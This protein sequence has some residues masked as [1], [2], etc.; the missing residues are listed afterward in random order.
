MH[1]SLDALRLN[2]RPT[3]WREPRAD[4][5]TQP[6]LEGRV[7]QSPSSTVPRL[8]RPALARTE[9]AFALLD[10]Y[11]RTG[12]FFIRTPPQDFAPVTQAGAFLYARNKM[13]EKESNRSPEP[14]FKV[15]QILILFALVLVFSFVVRLAGGDPL[16]TRFEIFFHQC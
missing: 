6:G 15:R 9:I 5:T 1:L 12:R 2:N 16:P 3:R 13:S 8:V 14:L 11:N 10:G 4:L 7:A